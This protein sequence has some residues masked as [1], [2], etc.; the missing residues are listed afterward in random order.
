[1]QQDRDVDAAG[2]DANTSL[3]RSDWTAHGSSN[4][5][6]EI[7]REPGYALRSALRLRHGH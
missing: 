7:L 5:L 3:C 1:M 4:T 2:R 6:G